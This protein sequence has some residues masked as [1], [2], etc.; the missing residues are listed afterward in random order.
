MPVC[1]QQTHPQQLPLYLSPS[2]PVPI[3]HA[4]ARQ[5][6]ELLAA[7]LRQAA[8]PEQ[9]PKSLGAEDER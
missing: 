4:V 8:Q 5:A 1:R 2:P 9:A 7:L 3:P 6:V